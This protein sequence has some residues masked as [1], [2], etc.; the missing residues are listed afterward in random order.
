MRSLSISLFLVATALL[1]GCSSMVTPSYQPGID[2]VETL[3]RQSGPVS[4]G[5][6][7]VA[8]TTPGATTLSM[9]GAN[10]M[11]S[12]VGADYAAY[13]AEALRQELRMAGKLDPNSTVVISGTLLKN[14]LDISG[15]ST[16]SAQLESRFVVTRGGVV[17]FDSIKKVDSS[18]GSSFAAA[19]AIPRASQ[20]YPLVVRKLI[21]A[22]LADPDF[23]S[24]I[25]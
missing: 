22:L 5:T 15:F 25:K 10:T 11:S 8:A 7:N 3:K 13:L 24:S 1:T 19:V 12:S 4:V 20:E 23:L 14:S 17:K 2:N 9:R 16:A 6:F 21:E 18:W